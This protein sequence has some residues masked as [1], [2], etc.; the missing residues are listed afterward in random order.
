MSSE[1]AY[2]GA[3]FFKCA[4]Q[5]NSHGYIKQF[6][7]EQGPAENEYNQQLLDQ[8]RQNHI[9]VVGL[10]DHGS[11]DTSTSLRSYLAGEGITVF[12][13]FEIASSEKF[14]WYAYTRKMPRMLN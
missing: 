14:T 8:C 12:P 2:K 7:G 3:R 13:G 11:I 1:A 4:L 10:A 5:V 9:Q 6:R